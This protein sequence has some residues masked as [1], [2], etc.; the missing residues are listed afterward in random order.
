MPTATQG[1]KDSRRHKD[2]VSGTTL[3]VF[4]GGATGYGALPLNNPMWGRVSFASRN[5]PCSLCGTRRMSQLPCSLPHSR[6]RLI[7]SRSALRR[8]FPCDKANPRSADY[9]Q[10]LTEHQR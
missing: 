10:C 9:T 2:P 4:S 7:A 3:G 6:R 1:K 8:R 5:P